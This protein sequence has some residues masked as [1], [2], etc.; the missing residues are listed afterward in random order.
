VVHP[1]PGML[2]FSFEMNLQIEVAAECS[3][4]IFQNYGCRYLSVC[5]KK[6]MNQIEDAE[7]D[8]EIFYNVLQASRSHLM[9]LAFHLLSCDMSCRYLFQASLQSHQQ[10]IYAE[11]AMI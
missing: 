11:A 6:E 7:T 3:L 9:I 1:W 10:A 5:R 2:Y 8:Q 4:S